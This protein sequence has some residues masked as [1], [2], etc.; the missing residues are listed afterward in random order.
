MFRH[1]IKQLA[2]ANDL[3]DYSIHYD[4]KTNMV[5]LITVIWYQK[6]EEKKQQLEKDKREIYKLKNSLT[7][8]QGEKWKNNIYQFPQGAERQ[9][10]KIH[11]YGK[12]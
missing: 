11:Q 1:N 8:K 9:V 6:Q 12:A 7:T 2:N 5:I 4:V 3:P 10:V